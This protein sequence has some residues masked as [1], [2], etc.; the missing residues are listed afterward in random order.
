VFD[1][2]G[3]NLAYI[4]SESVNCLAINLGSLPWLAAYMS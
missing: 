3:L 1:S 2:V 4:T